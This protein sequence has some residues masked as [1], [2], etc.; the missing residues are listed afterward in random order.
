[1]AVIQVTRERT[2]AFRLYRHGLWPKRIDLMEAL[3]GTGFLPSREAAYLAC[4]A[5]V[6]G[7]KRDDLDRSVFEDRAMVEL[8]TAGGQP[9]LVPAEIAPA[10]IRCP[11]ARERRSADATLARVRASMAIRMTLEEA[12]LDALGAGGLGFKELREHLADLG[13]DIPDWAGRPGLLSAILTLQRLDGE[14]VRTV[15]TPPLDAGEVVFARTGTLLPGEDVLS[16]DPEEALAK[17]CAWYFRIH[18]P[19]TR[20]DFGWWCGAGADEAST[21]FE[22]Q[23]SGLSPIHIEGVPYELFMTPSGL[24][25]LMD[26]ESLLPDPVHLVP[27]RDSWLM[28]HESRA[29]R[30][31][32]GE[33]IRRLGPGPVLPALLVSGEVRGRWT[34]LAQSGEVELTWFTPPRPKVRERADAVARELGAFV[35]REMPSIEPLTL[36]SPD[37]EISIYH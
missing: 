11:G 12:V 21:A 22:F 34:L 1:M 24:A 9:F 7:F 36:P 3:V 17:L 33:A 5:R 30:F 10:V 35:S 37:G 14:V 25:E 32:G 13:G 6:E 27:W 15:L 16:L 31:G 20:A 19:A 4:A 8:A 2:N 18:G 28:S 23:R 26:F 29:G